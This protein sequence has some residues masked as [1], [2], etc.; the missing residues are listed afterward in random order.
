MSDYMNAVLLVAKLTKPD[1]LRLR[2]HLTS[3]LGTGASIPDD[4]SAKAV[5][6][7]VLKF[8]KAKGLY[9]GHVTIQEIDRVLATK[10]GKAA[11][12]KCIDLWA[13]ISEQT[14][15]RLKREALL[16]L[17]LSLHY[18]ELRTWIDVV[19]VNQILQF[20]ERVPACFE[21]QFPGYASQKLLH[22]IVSMRKGSKRNG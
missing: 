8:M 3:L 21:S 12:Q 10:V 9:E 15:D 18:D 7:Q 1:Q 6:G 4:G 19:G 5:I 17:G 22:M 13:Y 14:E 11:V 20:L 16:Q 2:N